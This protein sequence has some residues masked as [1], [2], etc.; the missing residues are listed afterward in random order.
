MH[1]W[2]TDVLIADRETAIRL[3]EGNARVQRGT[4]SSQGSRGRSCWLLEENG[5]E[6]SQPSLRQGPE[7]WDRHRQASKEETAVLVGYAGRRVLFISF[8]IYLHFFTLLYFCRFSPSSMPLTR[9][10][11]ASRFWAVIIDLFYLFLFNDLYILFYCCCFF[12]LS[13]KGKVT[14]VF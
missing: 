10:R 14:R 6:I 8:F 13:V 1:S 4:L 2:T 9:A 12:L 3:P 7:R 11:Q 5:E